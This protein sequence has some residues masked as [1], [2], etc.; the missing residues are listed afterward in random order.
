MSRPPGRGRRLR[1]DRDNTITRDLESSEFARWKARLPQRPGEVGAVEEDREAF[2]VRVLVAQR[3]DRLTFESYSVRKR[4]WDD[5]WASVQEGLDESAV[6]PTAG[7]LEVLP[8]P[9]LD[10]T[11]AAVADDTWDSGSLNDLP[12][13]RQGHTAVWTGSLMI[14]WGG[15]DAG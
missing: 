3:P 1:Q 9:S 8:S 5:W 10:V 4:G 6:Q 7:R 12:V 13:P 2:V 15:K 11:A 14:V